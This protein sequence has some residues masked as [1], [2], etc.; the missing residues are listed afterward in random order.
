M[1][2]QGNWLLEF[3]LSL[4]F[5]K[6]TQLLTVYIHNPPRI[7]LSFITAAAAL[8]YYIL[9]DTTGKC[10]YFTLI[11]HKDLLV[12][13]CQPWLVLR[14]AEW[15]QDSLL[16]QLHSRIGTKHHF[17]LLLK[18]TTPEWNFFIWLHH[19]LEAAFHLCR[20]LII[21]LVELNTHTHDQTIEGFLK[22][23]MSVWGDCPD[24]F[25]PECACSMSRMRNFFVRRH[26][27]GF[28]DKQTNAGGEGRGF[29]SAVVPIF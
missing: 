29:R 28:I 24:L 27:R 9:Q 7:G 20:T 21:S 16:L 11:R 18:P 14:S 6:P 12:L 22:G 8:K 10:S 19:I 17:F 15:C 25:D 26:S 1:L 5:V 13:F 3:C 4:Q 2:C 23:I